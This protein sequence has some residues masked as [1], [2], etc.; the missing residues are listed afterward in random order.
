MAFDSIQ[1]NIQ[2]NFSLTDT[3]TS[4]VSNSSFSNTDSLGKPT[5]VLRDIGR[6]ITEK[7]IINSIPTPP[8]TLFVAEWI[9]YLILGAF[10]LLTVLNFL[11]RKSL[12]QFFRSVFEI[13]QANL[14][15]REGN[16]FRKRATL[17]FTLIYAIS[18]PLLFYFSFEKFIPQTYDIDFGLSLFF[19]IVCLVFCFF[20]FKVL[21]I[22]FTALIFQ[23]QKKS[24]ELLINILIFNLVIGILILPI[25]TLYTYTHLSIFL[26]IGLAIFGIGMTIRLFREIVIG[27]THSIFSILHLFLYLCTLEFIPIVIVMKLLINY[28]T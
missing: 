8:K 27:L 4:Q 6:F 1:K 21:F 15:I 9:T 22:Q 10:V 5:E 20:I 13:N 14:L 17:I 11:H 23:T 2:T 18:I 16:I 3:F 28:Y 12:L 25:I 19:N 24:S 7:D 26:F